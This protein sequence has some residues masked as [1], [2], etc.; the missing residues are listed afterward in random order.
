MTPVY[1]CVNSSIS[2]ALEPHEACQNSWSARPLAS[3]LLLRDALE[4]S[5]LSLG[6]RLSSSELARWLQCQCW[7]LVDGETF[8]SRCGAG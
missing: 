1:D 6:S 7:S 8:W 2:W 4:L 5:S 3:C